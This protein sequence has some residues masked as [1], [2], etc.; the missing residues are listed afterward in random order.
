LILTLPCQLVISIPQR[1]NFGIFLDS[2]PDRWGRVLMQRRENAHAR[3]EKR[4]PRALTELD[5]LLGVHDE[6][7]LGALRFREEPHSSFIDS[8][9]H[10]R[11]HLSAHC[12]NYRPPVC[13]SRNTS[14]MKTIP[15]MKNG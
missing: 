15:S 3:H 11:H 12:V 4:K 2:A 6:T 8:N 13:S 7:R 5:F 1:Q 9:T 14:T 10:L